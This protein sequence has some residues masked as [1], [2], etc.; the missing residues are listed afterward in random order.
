MPL[1][2]NSIV[3][4]K[5]VTIYQVDGTNKLL[6]KYDVKTINGVLEL[7]FFNELD[8][9][10]LILIAENEQDD[11]ESIYYDIKLSDLNF[12]LKKLD[13][14]LELK[15]QD[16]QKKYFA[17][18]L[19]NPDERQRLKETLIY[20]QDI[21]VDKKSSIACTSNASNDCENDLN[22]VVTPKG[23][24]IKFLFICLKTKLYI[25]S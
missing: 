17:V 9:V 22:D 5:N 2:D 23:F 4:Y 15:R 12:D 10:H 19:S 14:L 1:N 21:Y 6:K 20:L 7:S 8:E 3:V 13:S 25:F 11:Q 16:N 18:K 24:K